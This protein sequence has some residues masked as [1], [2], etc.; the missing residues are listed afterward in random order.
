MKQWLV[1]VQLAVSG[2]RVWQTKSVSVIVS[3][4]PGMCLFQ[5]HRPTPSQ[6]CV[7]WTAI[8]TAIFDDQALQNQAG[9]G[10]L[11]AETLFH[12]AIDTPVT[13]CEDEEL[14]W[15]R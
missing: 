1:E 14:V 4:P 12:P 11:P 13:P 10:S 7:T 5:L 6:T 2:Y 9:L 15:A 8:L 3:P